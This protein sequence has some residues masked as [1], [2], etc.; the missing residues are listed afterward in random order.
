MPNIQPLPDLDA[1]IVA[2]VAFFK[3]MSDEAFDDL[4]KRPEWTLVRR[5]DGGAYRIDFV[6]GATDEQKKA[7]LAAAASFDPSA[8]ENQ[9]APIASLEDR[10]DA[11]AAENDDL[12]K[13]I[14][15]LEG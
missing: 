11:L 2:G 6:D 7:A 12:K 15:A 13:R 1:T 10:L 4:V 3:P 8:P 14:A 9:P 5:E